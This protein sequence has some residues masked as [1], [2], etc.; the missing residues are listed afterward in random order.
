MIKLSILFFILSALSFTYHIQ[1]EFM[2]EQGWVHE[3]IFLPF[4][5]V[6]LFIALVLYGYHS[7]VKFLRKKS[8][9]S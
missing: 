6:F 8:H 3:T 4:S 5:Y 1:N 2:D 9:S 7:F